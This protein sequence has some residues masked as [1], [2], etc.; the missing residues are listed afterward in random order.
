MLLTGG[1][2][3][4]LDAAGSVVDS[5]VVRDGRIVFAGSRQDINVPAGEQVRDLG[6][7]AVLPGLV[8][9]HAHLMLLA[10]AR[11]AID[12]AGVRS[13]EAAAALVGAASRRAAPGEWLTGRGWDQT[14]WEGQRFPTKASLDRVA[15]TH[16]VA[17]TRVD[18][19]ATWA[20][21][22]ALVMPVLAARSPI[23]PGAAS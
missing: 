5:L 21:S 8:D 23:P 11:L 4:T 15:P 6:G 12:L 18:G 14:L 13:E 2:F 9:A 19:H 20:N 7:R 17:L 16:P 1:R 3:Y 10:R 22:A